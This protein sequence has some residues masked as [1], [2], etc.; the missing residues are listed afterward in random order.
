MASARAQPGQAGNYEVAESGVVVIPAPLIVALKPV[1][2]FLVQILADVRL[3]VAVLALDISFKRLE[4]MFFC[5]AGLPI[6]VKHIRQRDERLGGGKRPHRPVPF[7]TMSAA[8]RAELGVAALGRGDAERRGESGR[9]DKLQP[10]VFIAAVGQLEIPGN[11]T[12]GLAG[13]GNRTVLEPAD[14]EKAGLIIPQSRLHG[15]LDFGGLGAIA[16]G[17]LGLAGQS[18]RLGDRQRIAVHVAADARAAALL[19]AGAVDG[20][21]HGVLRFKLPI[22]AVRSPPGVCPSLVI[23]DKVVEHADQERPVLVDKVPLIRRPCCPTAVFM[24]VVPLA[25]RAAKPI[26]Q[27]IVQVAIVVNPPAFANVMPNRAADRVLISKE[28]GY[29]HVIGHL[30]DVLAIGPPAIIV[31]LLDVLIRAFEKRDILP[32]PIPGLRVGNEIHDVLIFHRVE[33]IDIVLKVIGL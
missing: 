8:V 17:H 26:Q 32:H 7:A 22:S 9:V 10:G 14:F 1:A 29:G 18:S 27:V 28:L 13:V 21:L 6:I 20:I 24:V 31:Y 33:P 12:D 30:L 3:A 2:V 16:R 25:V 23:A 4:V 19:F 15:L 5:N 11:E